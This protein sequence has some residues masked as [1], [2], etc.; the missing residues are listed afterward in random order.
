MLFF[1]T[2]SSRLDFHTLTPAT[3]ETDGKATELRQKQLEGKNALGHRSLDVRWNTKG[4]GVSQLTM[5]EC[6]KSVTICKK[7][8]HHISTIFRINQ[9][10]L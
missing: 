1:K 7:V 10:V 3:F 4:A 8:A 6:E 5:D 2:I 9:K